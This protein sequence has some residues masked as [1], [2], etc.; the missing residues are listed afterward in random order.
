MSEES[1]KTPVAGG[2]G[3]GGAPRPAGKRQV[4]GAAST[5]RA[6]SKRKAPEVVKTRSNPFAAIVDFIRGVIREIGKVIWPTGK[7]MVTYTFVVLGFLILMTVLVA[8]V[9]WGARELVK[10]M[11]NV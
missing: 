8:G 1:T 9:D 5:S 7:E 6:A 11:F 4:A 3:N 10:L 2:C